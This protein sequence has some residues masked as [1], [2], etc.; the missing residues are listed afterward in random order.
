MT[1]E[2][3]LSAYFWARVLKTDSCWLWTGHCRAPLPYGRLR[4]RSGK[5]PL[6][7]YAHRVSWEIHF[8]PIP[9][10]AFVCHHC[11]NPQCVNPD[12]LFLGT[13]QDNMADAH[14]KGRFINQGKMVCKFGHLLTPENTYT[15][16][17]PSHRGHPNR[18][19]RTC[20]RKHYKNFHLRQKLKAQAS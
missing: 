9:D 11:D 2:H 7:P 3:H 18:R 19:C 10:E 17:S 12:H 8:G 5:G 6:Q 4:D 13:Q 1:T 15:S 16:N 14:A 20:Q